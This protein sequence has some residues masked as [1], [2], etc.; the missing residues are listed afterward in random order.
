MTC[1]DF[2][3]RVCMR[4]PCKMRHEVE[5][6]KNEFCTQNKTC[7]RMHLTDC[8]VNEINRNIRP[9][10]KSVNDEMYRLAYILRDSFPPELKNHCCTLNML[11][12]CVW[13][14]AVCRKSCSTSTV[15]VCN[16]C[17]IKLTRSNI[18]ALRCGHTYCKYCF[19]LLSFHV[20]G[21]LPMY[22]CKHCC[23][24]ATIFILY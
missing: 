12:Q 13:M 6:C 19:D 2:M 16:K 20:D 8:E 18:M 3:L 17:Y 9:F 15:P 11:G 22:Y 10:R 4:N 24:W 1:R 14:C 21:P 7:K 23:E 5:K